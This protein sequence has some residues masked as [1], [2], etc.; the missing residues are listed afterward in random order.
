MR[1]V[2]ALDKWCFRDRRE[3]ALTVAAFKF[4]QN[5]SH[6]DTRQ[7][8]TRRHDANL[9]NVSW[10]KSVKAQQSV[11]YKNGRKSGLY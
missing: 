9:V 11:S 8:H 3:K 2:G 10:N 1:Y 4:A 6:L 7:I 5:P